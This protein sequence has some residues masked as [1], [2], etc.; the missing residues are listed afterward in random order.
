MFA[1]VTLHQVQKTLPQKRIADIILLNQ[2]NDSKRDTNTIKKMS[3]TGKKG[4]STMKKSLHPLYEFHA[5][6]MHTF[7]SDH[8]LLERSSSEKT[9]VEQ[10]RFTKTNS[11]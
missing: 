11:F 8:S 4:T 9:G 7:K 1:R 10:E 2:A 3:R 5:S 6:K